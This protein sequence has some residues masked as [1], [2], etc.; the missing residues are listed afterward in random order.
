MSHDVTLVLLDPGGGEEQDVEDSLK[1]RLGLVHIL[2]DDQPQ[3]VLDVLDNK[4]RLKISAEVRAGTRVGSKLEQ[5][6]EQ[7]LTQI[8]LQETRKKSWNI[9]CKLMN[10]EITEVSRILILLSSFYLTDEVVTKR[11]L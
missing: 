1:L 2:D 11:H 9:S 4:I 7:I 3:E 10:L 6:R 5:E 8:R